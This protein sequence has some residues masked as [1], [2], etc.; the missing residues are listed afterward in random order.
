LFDKNNQ[1]VTNKACIILFSSI[2]IAFHIGKFSIF[3]TLDLK[4]ITT[5]GNCL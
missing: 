1:S 3:A 5:E 4:T 2:E